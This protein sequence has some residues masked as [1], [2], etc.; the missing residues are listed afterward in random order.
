MNN[1]PLYIAVAN[2]MQKGP[3]Y[4]RFAKGSTLETRRDFLQKHRNVISKVT[5]ILPREKV[6]VLAAISKAGAKYGVDKAVQFA[7]N[8]RDCTF[9]GH[10][11]PALKLWH[12]LLN[13]KH[14][15]VPIY[16]TTIT[17]VRAFCEGRTLY[18]IREA[19]SDIEL[20]QQ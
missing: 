16:K 3:S 12:Y 20:E 1:D 11:D 13:T 2:Q 9:N 10:D 6:V 19:E 17:A 15:S 14:D 18:K 5:A 8:L 7:K 4:G